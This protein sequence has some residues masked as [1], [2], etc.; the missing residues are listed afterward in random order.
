LSAEDVAHIVE[1]AKAH[2]SLSTKLLIFQVKERHDIDVT[3]AQIG[4]LRRKKII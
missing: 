2:P 3:S 1:I 4:A